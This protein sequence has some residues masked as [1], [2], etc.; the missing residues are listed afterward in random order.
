MSG[1]TNAGAEELGLEGDSCLCAVDDPMG[2]ALAPVDQEVP[3]TPL[4]T[5]CP[6]FF[7]RDG[8]AYAVCFDDRLGGAPA[9]RFLVR[10]E[11]GLAM[12]DMGLKL[13]ALWI[14][15]AML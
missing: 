5:P 11:L 8:T 13:F 7:E 10:A 14:L 9:G 3:V 1:L 4:D 2:G 15:A 6:G 12:L